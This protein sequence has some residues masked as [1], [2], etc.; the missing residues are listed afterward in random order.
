MKNERGSHQVE[1]P[2]VFRRNQP[3]GGEFDGPIQ[4]TLI[5]SL[6]KM[7]LKKG[8]E[9]LKKGSEAARCDE[10]L[11]YAKSIRDYPQAQEW[12]LKG[13]AWGTAIRTVKRGK[14]KEELRDRILEK[15]HS[16]YNNLHRKI[17]LRR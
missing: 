13:V 10:V 8:E 4:E 17:N 15:A 1:N 6:W 16:V 2:F 9:A 14:S 12:Y 11:G 5:L 3:D 7:G